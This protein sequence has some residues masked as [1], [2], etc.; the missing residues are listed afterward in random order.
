MVQDKGFPST[1]SGAMPFLAGIFTLALGIPA[2]VSLA[3]DDAFRRGDA[4]AD[5]AVNLGD[6]ITDL[7]YLFAAAGEPPCLAAADANGSNEI[8][9]AD[10]VFLLNYLFGSGREPPAPYPDCGAFYSSPAGSLTCESFAP[11]N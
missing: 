2:Q 4:N 9:I 5:G 11:C 1:N 6:A 10:A 7:S 8:N 3:A